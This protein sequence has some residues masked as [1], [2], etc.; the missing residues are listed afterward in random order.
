MD[1]DALQKF[2]TQAQKLQ[3]IAREIM[4][5]IEAIRE[6]DGREVIPT[7]T[8]RLIR[9]G[10][11]AQILGVNQ[12]TIGAFVREG[13]LKPYYVNSDQKKF[14][15]SDVKALPRRTPWTLRDTYEQRRTSTA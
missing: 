6:L 1:L 3:E 14:W 10:D 12:S 4:P 2:T 9:A 13:L 7:P 11:A 15:L 5:L 8:D